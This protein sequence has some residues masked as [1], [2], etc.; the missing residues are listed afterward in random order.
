MEVN[1][2]TWSE[3]EEL[4]WEDDLQKRF[5]TSCGSPKVTHSLRGYPYWPYVEWAQWRSEQLGWTVVELSG[6]TKSKPSVCTECNQD[7]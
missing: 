7:Q 2:K 4:K 1:N 5:C 3:E 6:C